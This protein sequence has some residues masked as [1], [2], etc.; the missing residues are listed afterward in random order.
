[1]QQCL[2]NVKSFEFLELH[3][4]ILDDYQRIPLLQVFDVKIDLHHKVRLVAGG[5]VMN[6]I[7]SNNYSG[8]IK[9][10]SVHLTFLF[11]NLNKPDLVL[12][13]DKSNAYLYTVTITEKVY[14]ICKMEFRAELK[15]CK[16]ISIQKSLYGLKSSVACWH[17]KL[18]EFLLSLGFNPCF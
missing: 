4:T 5:H 7:K 2:K 3:T 17:K 11:A 6:D 1:M 12:M 14:T 15:G 13:A 9:S 16:V 10:D 8:V 18:S